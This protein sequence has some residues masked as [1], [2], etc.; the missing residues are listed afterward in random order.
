MLLRDRFDPIRPMRELELGD[1]GIMHLNAETRASE[2]REMESSLK[3]SPVTFI[4]LAGHVIS[5]LLVDRARVDEVF[6]KMIHELKHIALHGSRD[7]DVVDEGEVDHIFAKPD[8]SSMGANRDA[9]PAPNGQ[10]IR[11]TARGVRYSLGGHQ[12]HSQNL[13]HTR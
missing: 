11:H 8:T 2:T 13:A 4:R 7:S 1:A 6:M 12:K 5:T 3:A 10:S 9:K